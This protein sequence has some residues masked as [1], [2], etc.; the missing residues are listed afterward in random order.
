MILVLSLV[1]SCSRVTRLKRTRLKFS[2]VALERD[3]VLSRR[4]YGDSKTEFRVPRLFLAN[5][6]ENLV[7][8]NNMLELEV[9]L[10]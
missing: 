1:E 10:R 2:L 9:P 7:K 4:S 5:T 3:K 8:Q 6:W